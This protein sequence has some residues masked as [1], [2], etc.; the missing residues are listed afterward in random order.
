M[1]HQAEAI[2]RKPIEWKVFSEALTLPAALRRKSRRDA[3]CEDPT[4][5]VEPPGC[6]FSPM[7]ER[8]TRKG[9]T[10]ERHLSTANA[11]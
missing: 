8:T 3:R 4:L 10:T 1:G 7:C 2:G 5:R 11:S 6:V 9:E